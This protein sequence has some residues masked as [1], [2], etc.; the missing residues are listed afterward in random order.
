MMERMILNLM[1]VSV[2]VELKHLKSKVEKMTMM[3]L[4]L[5]IVVQNVAN[6][7]KRNHLLVKKYA[8]EI[9]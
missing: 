4:I 1:M 7:Q 3:N 8:V 9:V 6:H 5:M 2:N